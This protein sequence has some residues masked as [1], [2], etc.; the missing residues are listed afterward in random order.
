MDEGTGKGVIKQ[1]LAETVMFFR[2]KNDQTCTVWMSHSTGLGH[3]TIK[4]TL[5]ARW[6]RQYV[7]G[8]TEGIMA[9]LVY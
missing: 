1:E 5:M 6:V 3:W 2:K 4:L 9:Y 7:R 8:N